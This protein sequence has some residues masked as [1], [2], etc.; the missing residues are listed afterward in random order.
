M[1]AF[2]ILVS[3]VMAMVDMYPGAPRIPTMPQLRAPL[4]EVGIS[5][6]ISAVLALLLMRFFPKTPLYGILVSQTASGVRSDLDLV[7]KQVSRA[8]QVGVALSALR[9]GGKA[10]FGDDIIDVISQGDLVDKGQK[11][12]IIGHSGTEAIVEIVS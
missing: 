5:L 4:Q 6:L 12:R 9:P 2:L 8:G 7:Q 10:Q 1:G 11:V 3:L